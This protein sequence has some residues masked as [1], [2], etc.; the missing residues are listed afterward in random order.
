MKEY[1]YSNKG[2]LCIELSER[3][4][5]STLAPFLEE[6]NGVKY[7]NWQQKYIV[8]MKTEECLTL[9]KAIDVLIEKNAEEFHKFCQKIYRNDK[10]TNIVFVHDKSKNNSLNKQMVYFGLQ[11]NKGYVSFTL[12]IIDTLSKAEV[13][14][15]QV[16]IDNV[17]L[18]R[19]SCFLKLVAT[20]KMKQG[21]SN[22]S[23]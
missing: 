6:K 10:Y 11:E 3:G 8:S 5:F 7:Y 21:V 18:I 16:N 15:L 22:G 9:A 1:F 12:K 23:I 19:L 4:I 20:E 13:F 14:N 17:N 2:A